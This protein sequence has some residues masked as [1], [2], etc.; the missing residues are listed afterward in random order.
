MF[1]H[2]TTQHRQ[3][4][5]STGGCSAAAA[6]A[7][8]RFVSLP[9]ARVSLWKVCNY[10]SAMQD[11][12]TPPLSGHHCKLEVPKPWEGLLHVH[13]HLP[14]LQTLKKMMW[15]FHLVIRQ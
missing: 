15:L 9:Q 12:H 13:V 7:A 10:D 5:H 4:Q 11:P 8:D 14:C 1:G 2:Q 6:A 3:T